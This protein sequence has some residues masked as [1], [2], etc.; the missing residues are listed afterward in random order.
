MKII[1][2]IEN[3]KIIRNYKLD[4]WIITVTE[5][6]GLKGKTDFKFYLTG[7]GTTMY[8]FGLN[9]ETMEAIGLTIES[10]IENNLEEQIAAFKKTYD[11]LDEI[12]NPYND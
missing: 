12:P 7:L 4:D 3:Q 6:D 1:E 2:K 10:A 11:K 9:K 8:M 5:I